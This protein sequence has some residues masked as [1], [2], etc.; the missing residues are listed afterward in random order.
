MAERGSE[1]EELLGTD[2]PRLVHEQARAWSAD[3]AQ[4]LSEAQIE[5]LSKSTTAHLGHVLECEDCAMRARL[6]F[7]AS[8]APA[9]TVPRR[10]GRILRGG[11]LA[12]AAG[13]A[14]FVAGRFSGGGESAGPELPAR[15]LALFDPGASRDGSAPAAEIRRRDLREGKLAILVSCQCPGDVVSWVLKDPE[16]QSLR[17]EHRFAAPAAAFKEFVLEADLARVLAPNSNRLELEI[18]GQDGATC[19]HWVIRVGA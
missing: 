18:Q 14:L 5:S 1:P 19:A 11:A 2:A 12:A 3:Q 7:A 17:G 16:G 13:L 8:A 6:R 9:L 10:R 15:S 4:H